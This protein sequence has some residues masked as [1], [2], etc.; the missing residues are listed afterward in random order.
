MK[1]YNSNRMSSGSTRRGQKKNGKHQ[2]DGRLQ[3]RKTD[4]TRKEPTWRQSR[5]QAYY[6]D[7][8][9]QNDSLRNLPKSDKH[10]IPTFPNTKKG[11]DDRKK[12]YT[13]SPENQKLRDL[14][15]LGIKMRKKH[16]YLK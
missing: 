9:I 6:E 13:F 1:G 3:E 4:T 14:R 8:R 2:E 11:N 12:F 5:T 7:M 16:G 10:H 15:K